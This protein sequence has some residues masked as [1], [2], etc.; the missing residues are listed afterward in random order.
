VDPGVVQALIAP[1]VV[2]EISTE[3]SGPRRQ[4][5]LLAGQAALAQQ[6]SQRNVASADVLFETALGLVYCGEVFHIQGFMVERLGGMAY[7]YRVSAVS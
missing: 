4:I 5:E 2:R 1:V 7:L 3:N 6:V